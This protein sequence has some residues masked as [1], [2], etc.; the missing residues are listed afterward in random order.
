MATNLQVEKV[1]NTTTQVVE[2]ENGNASSLALS[3]GNIGIGT[4]S[5]NGKLHVT[6]N[7]DGN[8]GALTLEGDKPTIRFSG[9]ALVG[10]QQWIL[11]LGSEGPGN[12]L[13]F[14][15]DTAGQH[16]GRVMSLKPSGNVEFPGNFDGANGGLTLTGDKPTIRFS[17]NAM[18]GNQ[19]WILHLGSDGPGN[20]QFFNGG[21]A[22]NWG[23]PVLSLTPDGNVEVRGDIRLVNA[24]CAEDFNISSVGPA[25]PGTVMVLGDEDTLQPSRYAYDKR[26][27]GVI[28]GAGNYRPGLVLDKKAG[29]KNRQAVALM[30]KVFCKVDAEYEPIQV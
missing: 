3:T 22:G 23:L 8:F 13:F 19:Q 27:A 5:P 12:L 6:G 1:L 18:V 24:D 10:Q 2:D 7:W 14:N 25:E 29:Q 9:G 26:V 4:T 17:G 20:L 30:G 11:H 15:G 21:T 28:S 16:W